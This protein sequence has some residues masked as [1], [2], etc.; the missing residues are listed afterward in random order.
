MG[1][2]VGEVSGFETEEVV[3]EQYHRKWE[4]SGVFLGKVG[5]DSFCPI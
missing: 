3:F 1:G 2:W 5:H 4:A